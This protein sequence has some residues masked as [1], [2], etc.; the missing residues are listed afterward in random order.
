LNGEKMDVIFNPVGG[1]TFKTD[2][3]LLEH[4][5]RIFLFG[6]AELSKGRFGLLSQLNFLRKMGLVL[7][8]G[9]MMGSRSIL[10]IN[11][12][13]IADQKPDVLHHCLEQV[14]QLFTEGHI[15]PVSG[16]VYHHEQLEKAHFAL[17]SG[18]TVGKIAIT[19]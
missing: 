18:S 7:P 5:G 19:W 3:K 1:S 11:M 8:I 14:V 4:G 2:K 17:E 12:L 15:R 16:G 9:L 10:G 6:G 13:K